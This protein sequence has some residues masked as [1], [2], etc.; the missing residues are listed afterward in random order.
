MQRMD[1]NVRIPMATAPLRLAL[2]PEVPT[3]LADAGFRGSIENEVS[4]VL[5]GAAS[6]PNLTND[7]VNLARGPRGRA[8]LIEALADDEP[9]I[10][11]TNGE[12]RAAVLGALA[13]FGSD[14]MVQ[15]AL[16]SELKRAHLLSGTA[17]YTVALI[18][19]MCKI[20]TSDAAAAYLEV[21]KA[22]GSNLF[23]PD[24][25]AALRPEVA[26]EARYMGRD[27][28]RN[29]FKLYERGAE[30]S[31]PLVNAVLAFGGNSGLY[32]MLEFAS[33]RAARL[34]QNPVQDLGIKVITFA[35][36]VIGTSQAPAMIR[37]LGAMAPGH[38]GLI[39]RLAPG[40]ALF[41]ACFS[42][43]PLANL[44]RRVLNDPVI[45]DRGRVEV[46]R[47]L[48]EDA[49]KKP[50]LWTLKELA[51]KSAKD[52]SFAIAAQESLREGNYKPL[53]KLTL[54]LMLS[55]SGSNEALREG[56]ASELR[57]RA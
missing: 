56:I 8:V 5:A 47:A 36:I 16:F 51:R 49:Y 31:A 41:L 55:D 43:K 27:F 28:V 21:C 54:Q 37:E 48:R 34:Y 22:I 53:S 29:F 24:D 20:S 44:L 33:G 18:N 3:G 23:P 40:A 10:L 12:I 39:S 9:Y 46:I 50:V 7:L 17:R 19:Q 45:N 57:R 4:R 1:Q 25:L 42:F 6:N 15:I 30:P 2:S 14:E 35:A 13:H 52:L 11:R 26:P 38:A 32:R